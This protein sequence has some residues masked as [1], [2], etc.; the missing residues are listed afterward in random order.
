MRV[1]EA[2][3]DAACRAAAGYLKDCGLRIL[4]QNWRCDTEILPLIAAEDGTLVIIDLRV[5]AGTRYDAPLGAIGTTRRRAM[6]RLASRWQALHGV[7]FEQIRIDAVGL[8][9]D[10]TG[11]FTIEHIR[12]V[13]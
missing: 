5:R 12:A 1:K 9:Q 8:L 6:R 10:S 11:G 13:G 2:L 4:D 7:R 3:A